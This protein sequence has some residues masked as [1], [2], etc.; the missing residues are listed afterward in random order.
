MLFAVVP[1]VQKMLVV[2]GASVP[3]VFMQGSIAYAVLSVG[4]K[5]TLGV[6][7][8]FFVRLFQLV[9]TL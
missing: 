6:S 2:G 1:F 7:Y 8:I 4:V 3:Q 5:V 9:N